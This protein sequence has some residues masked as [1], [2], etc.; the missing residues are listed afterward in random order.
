MSRT[1]EVTITECTR[2]N[3]CYDCDNERCAFHGDKEADCPKY[4][5]DRPKEH[6]LDCD[7]CGFIDGFIR[8]MR[9]IY[10]EGKRE[11]NA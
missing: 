10:A 5:C 2:Q 6:Q 8:D 11:G 9:E 3:T 7:H 1:G 4:H